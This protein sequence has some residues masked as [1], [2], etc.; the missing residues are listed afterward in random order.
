MQITEVKIR[1]IFNDEGPLKAIAS[2]TFE[3]CFVV[4][5]IKVVNIKEKQFVVMPATKLADGTHRDIVHPTNAEFRAKLTEAVL[6]AYEI[7]KALETV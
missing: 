2:V 4:H 5:D 7:Q 3:G 1:K 6:E